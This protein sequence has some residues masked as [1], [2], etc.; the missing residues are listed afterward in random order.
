MILNYSGYIV[1]VD[2]RGDHGLININPEYPV[3]SLVFL[4]FQKQEDTDK[5]VPKLQKLKFDY[6]RHDNLVLHSHDIQKKKGPL[7][8]PRTNAQLRK[9]FY[10]NRNSMIGIVAFHFSFF[11]SVINKHKLI[12]KYPDPFNP[13]HIAL[14]FCLAKT[15]QFLLKNGQKGKRVSLV[16]ESRGRNKDSDIDIIIVF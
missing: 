9:N 12:K 13:Y 15:H 6:L 1:Y 5:V 7:A 4:V 14:H 3:F 10:N 2:E 8:L 11:A 16:V